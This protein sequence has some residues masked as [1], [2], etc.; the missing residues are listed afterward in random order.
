MKIKL[1]ASLLWMLSGAGS[2]Y[3]GTPAPG[4]LDGLVFVG[5]IKSSDKDAKAIAET[6]TGGSGQI[7]S[8]FAAELGFGA[9]KWIDIGEIS[10][11]AGSETLEIGVEATNEAKD[12][13]Q[14]GV[15]VQDQKSLTAT[16]RLSK[17]DGTVKDFRIEANAN[18][19][20]F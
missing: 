9:L 8:V 2:A 6:I 4:I 5:T 20:F 1:M 7:T 19:I 10:G 16:V 17:A 14:M 13:L 11:H 15:V 18:N 3:E 12:K